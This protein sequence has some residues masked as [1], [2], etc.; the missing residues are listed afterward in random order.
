MAPEGPRDHELAGTKPG[1]CSRPCGHAPRRHQDPM[2]RPSLRHEAPW[3]PMVKTEQ[4]H[5]GR[6]GTVFE[7]PRLSLPVLMIL[8]NSF[9]KVSRRN[10]PPSTQAPPWTVKV[11]KGAG[12]RG[13]ATLGP[14]VLL[15]GHS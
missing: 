11:T 13:P 4:N 14:A 15:Q 12:Q 6:L 10:S 1:D 3:W 2:H 9:S 7:S 5:T 8:A